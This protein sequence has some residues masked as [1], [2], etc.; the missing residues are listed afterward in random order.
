M[1]LSMNEISK[2]IE[3][4]TTA[5]KTINYGVYNF[6]M[7]GGIYL[8]QTLFDFGLEGL[9]ELSSWLDLMKT[10]VGGR[11][12]TDSKGNK[13]N[14][15]KESSPHNIYITL[16][17][18]HQTTNNLEQLIDKVNRAIFFMKK[19]GET[20]KE[21]IAN[22]QF[23]IVWLS[24]TWFD[25][26]TVIRHITKSDELEY[27][28]YYSL[29]I[30]GEPTEGGEVTRDL[31]EK[32]YKEISDRWIPLPVLCDMLGL[33]FDFYDGPMGSQ[34]LHKTTEMNEAIYNAIADL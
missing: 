20:V 9:E 3:E 1:K 31:T 15:S 6:Q 23:S 14:V 8:D 13:L 21:L 5:T 28:D 27:C 17:N 25:D 34:I 7:M 26:E 4:Q 30:V 10:N 16:N 24:T 19:N 29:V 12:F 18:E 2:A 32:Q 11:T 22:K 33:D